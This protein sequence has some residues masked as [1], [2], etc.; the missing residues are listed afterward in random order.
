MIANSLTTGTMPTTDTPNT[1]CHADSYWPT[2]LVRATESGWF[3]TEARMTKE[4][5]NSFQAATNVK[6]MAVD[7]LADDPH[8]AEVWHEAV[9]AP[10]E[11][12]QSR[13]RDRAVLIGAA[14]AA[15]AQA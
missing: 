6:M 4:A 9:V 3:S 7:R 5:E 12:V 2:N 13:W 1:Y 8:A 11:I 15:G 10:P 14:F